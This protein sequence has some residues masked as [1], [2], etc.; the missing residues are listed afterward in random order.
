MLMVS[1]APNVTVWP[2][3]GF[4]IPPL[5]ASLLTIVPPPVLVTSWFAAGF[6]FA[7]RSTELPGLVRVAL[8]LIAM[9]PS[10]SRTDPPR[11]RS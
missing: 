2:A 5:L 1:P 7:K 8:L 3:A 11:S 10:N 4:A 9:S 6:E